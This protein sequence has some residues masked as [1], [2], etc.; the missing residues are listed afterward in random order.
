MLHNGVSIFIKKKIITIKIKRGTERGINFTGYRVLRVIHFLREKVRLP[1]FVS[2][3][4]CIQA[5][6]HEVSLCTG[7]LQL[8]PKRETKLYYPAKNKFEEFDVFLPKNE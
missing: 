5:R 8:F 2:V 1:S 4:H 7:D 3:N 6:S